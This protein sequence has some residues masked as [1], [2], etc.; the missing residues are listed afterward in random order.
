VQ[1]LHRQTCYAALEDLTRV[2]LATTATSSPRI[3]EAR[4][5]RTFF[6]FFPPRIGEVRHGGDDKVLASARHARRDFFIFFNELRA[7]TDDIASA[8]A[9][10]LRA[11]GCKLKFERRRRRRMTLTHS[12]GIFSTEAI[13][14]LRCGGE[15]QAN[16]LDPHDPTHNSLSLLTVSH[17]RLELGLR[18][19]TSWVPE[20]SG[21][22][23]MPRSLAST[24]SCEY[25]TVFDL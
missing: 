4:S 21:T 19:G 24:L 2:R 20:P 6:I 1:I 14:T 17:S 12:Y 5:T 25:R 13:R 23:R 18:S 8:R 9:S 22:P 15:P 16:Q 3:G 10:L 11:L 7:V